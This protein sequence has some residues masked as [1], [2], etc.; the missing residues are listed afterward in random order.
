MSSGWLTRIIRL[1]RDAPSLGPVYVQVGDVIDGLIDG[2]V[3][4]WTGSKR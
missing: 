3:L 4:V 2:Q 1:V